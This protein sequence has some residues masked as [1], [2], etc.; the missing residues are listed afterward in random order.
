MEPDK[1]GLFPELKWETPE[2]SDLWFMQVHVDDESIQHQYH[3][4]ILHLPLNETSMGGLF[5]TK[6]NVYDLA[7]KYY[8]YSESD[9]RAGILYP[10]FTNS[11]S[12]SSL[13][14]FMNY[15]T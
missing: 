15:N 11:F 10:D 1:S 6:L 13:E 4:A 2:D 12:Y 9:I 3:K 8:N 14:I 7:P 5:K